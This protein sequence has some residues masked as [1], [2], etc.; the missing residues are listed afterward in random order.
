MD[1]VIS[2]APAHE[3]EL[4]RAVMN[5]LRHTTRWFWM[6]IGV[7]AALVV[8]LLVVL[9]RQWVLGLGVTGLG[10]PVYWGIYIT[11]FVFFIGISHAGTLISAI[12]RVTNAEWRRPITARPRR[13]PS[14]H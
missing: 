4:E 5:P 12:L 13:S 8:L 9:I 7:L 1:T 11:N 14:S 6:A 2:S 3:T 10:R